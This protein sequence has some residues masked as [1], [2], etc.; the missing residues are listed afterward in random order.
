MD[1]FARRIIGWSLSANADT[2]LVS[3]ALRMASEMCGQPRDVMFHSNQG[4]RL[5]AFNIS[6]FSGVTE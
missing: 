2:A 6:H 5:P 4:S 3:G 1:L